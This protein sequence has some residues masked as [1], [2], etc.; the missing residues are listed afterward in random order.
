MT[1][2]QDNRLG[3]SHL[4]TVLYFLGP[5]RVLEGVDLVI[6]GLGMLTIESNRITYLAAQTD[7]L[8]VRISRAAT[9]PEPRQSLLF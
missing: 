5:T 9:D 2:W 7:A 3:T 4:L 1:R 8:L 6:F